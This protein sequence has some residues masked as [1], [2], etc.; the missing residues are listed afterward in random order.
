MSQPGTEI[1]DTSPSN[2][3]AGVIISGRSDAYLAM[4]VSNDGV[5]ELEAKSDCA[6]MR[7]PASHQ[8][9]LRYCKS[10]LVQAFT[11]IELKHM[12]SIVQL[13]LPLMIQ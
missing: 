13:Q 9:A 8:N 10:I 1:V 3:L 7:D 11:Y 2:A 4:A 6:S 12:V 5:T